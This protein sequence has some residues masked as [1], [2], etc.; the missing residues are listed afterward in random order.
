MGTK[1]KERQ[2]RKQRQE[3]GMGEER[4]F[5]SSRIDTQTCPFVG[6]E[7]YYIC[8]S[9]IHIYPTYSSGMLFLTMHRKHTRS[10]SHFHFGG[11]AR[12]FHKADLFL[13]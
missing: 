8:S 10:F 11:R 2:R 4:N 3:Y 5:R 1:D 12:H 7:D 13:E 9:L 6:S